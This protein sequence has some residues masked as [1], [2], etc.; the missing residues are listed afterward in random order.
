MHGF[1]SRTS[2]FLN[3]KNECYLVKF[4]LRS[5]QGIENLTAAEA[6]AIVG[7]DRENH[8]RDLYESIEMG[9]FPKSTLKVKVMA[10]KD[11]AKLPYHPF[12]LTRVW[13]HR[14]GLPID[15]GVM[16]HNRNPENFFAEVEQAG[17]N[18]ASIVPGIGFSPDKM[19][20]GRL[21][22]YGDAQ[23]YRLGVNHHLIPVNAARCV[24]R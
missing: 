11:V 8:Q 24:A 9:D 17:F 13:L 21:F 10:E 14:D 4:H 7:K 12:D 19:L 5:Q 6:E 22:S 15:V 23:R 18:P 3:A 1:G 2:S 20:Q 16:E